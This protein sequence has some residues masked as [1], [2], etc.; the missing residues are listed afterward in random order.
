MFLVG[1][2][3]GCFVLFVG[4]RSGEVKEELIGRGLG[5]EVVGIVEVLDFI[6]LPFDEIVD[7]FDIG[8]EGV[9]SRVWWR[10]A[11]RG[12]SRRFWCKGLTFW[13]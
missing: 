4:V 12:C 8:L 10:D 5:D 11:G 7:G 1:E 2:L 13:P 6:E 9:G 3:P